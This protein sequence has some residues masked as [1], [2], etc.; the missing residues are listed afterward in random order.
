MMSEEE[1]KMLDEI[2]MNVRGAF[3]NGIEK[4]I[5]E[6]K[7]ENE[8]KSLMDFYQNYK[9]KKIETFPLFNKPKDIGDKLAKI[10]GELT[11]IF[12]FSNLHEKFATR[13]DLKDMSAILL[14]ISKEVAEVAKE[15]E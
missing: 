6:F 15:R 7:K 3:L 12:A 1:R 5:V 8:D 10:S 4:E 13:Q 11:I 2:F 9:E 14:Q